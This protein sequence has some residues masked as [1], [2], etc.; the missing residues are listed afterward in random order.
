MELPDSYALF[1]PVFRNRSGSR[2]KELVKKLSLRFPENPAQI[3]PSPTPNASAT[4]PSPTPAAAPDR[5]AGKSD[6]VVLIY[7]SKPGCHECDRVTATLA[8]LKEH[9]PEIEIQEW[10]INK[11]RSM[12]WNEALS[13]TFGVPDNLR[14][15][16]PAVFSAA[17]YLVRDDVNEARLGQLVLDSRGKPDDMLRAGGDAATAGGAAIE[18]RFED[19]HVGV[20]VAAGLLDGLNPCAFATIIFLL[21][22]LQV[23]RKTP[24]EILQIGIAYI[25][26]VFLTYFALGLGL[27]EIFGRALI[28]RWLSS[29]LNLAMG[30]FALVVAA[31]SLRDAIRCLQGRMADMTLQLPEALKSR[32][33]GLIR[34]TARHRHFVVMAF[35]VGAGISVLELACTGQVYA[36]T[37]IYMLQAGEGRAVG[38]L[39]AYNLAFVLPLTV[40][41]ALAF[42]GLTSSHLLAFFSRHA[43]IVKFAMAILFLILGLLLILRE[44]K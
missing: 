40:V 15:V 18:R 20:I 26:G 35:A 16:A 37:L 39:A 38:Y 6:A 24:R 2:E 21:S 9:F 1:T 30:A 36:P 27:I 28:L 14:L 33:H 43:A 41:F 34:S 31:L 5:A 32:I 3:A 4:A 19:I 23:A 17:G 12:E 44:W 8:R 42:F 10:N 13:E 29:A 7:F 11:N 22:Y 25:L